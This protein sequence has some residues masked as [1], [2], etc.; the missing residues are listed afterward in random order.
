MLDIKLM[1]PLLFSG[2]AGEVVTAYTL[3]VS[4]ALSVILPSPLFLSARNKESN[5]VTSR[6]F[7]LEIIEKQSLLVILIVPLSLIFAS[8]SEVALIFV[9][10]ASASFLS[11]LRSS[12]IT[13]SLF[14][15]VLTLKLASCS[16]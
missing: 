9:A 14:S 4:Q 16:S 12:S 13:P 7:T 6:L 10:S 11:V 1:P 15:S 8:Y 3:V 5:L 2:E